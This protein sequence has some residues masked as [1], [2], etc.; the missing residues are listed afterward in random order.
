M[1]TRVCNGGGG[2][3]PVH[4]TGRAGPELEAAALHCAHK[5]V[6]ADDDDDD[7]DDDDPPHTSGSPSGICLL[8][9]FAA[10]RRPQTI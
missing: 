2:C 4:V 10:S 7:D 1:K 3:L 5:A 6:T 9:P 8:P